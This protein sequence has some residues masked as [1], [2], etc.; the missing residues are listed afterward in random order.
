MLVRTWNLFHGNTQPP[1]RRAFLRQMIQLVT[2]DEPDVVCLQEV[3]VWAVRL[4]EHWSGMQRVS[5]V[6]RRPR[7][8]FGRRPTQLHHGFLRSA[9]TGEA[10][11]ILASPRYR[12]TDARS[13][14]VSRSGLRRIVHGA[15]L[16]GR[17]YI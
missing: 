15:R 14:V 13:A 12:L 10:D 7:V 2:Q 11:A 16:D 17:V 6:A 5:A 3:P 9:L 4:L 8:P 1:Q